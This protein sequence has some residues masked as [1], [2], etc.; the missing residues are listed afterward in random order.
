MK[1]S[2]IS[3]VASS[4][5][6]ALIVITDVTEQVNRHLQLNVLVVDVVSDN[7]GNV[8]ICRVAPVFHLGN[9][10]GL[11]SDGVHESVAVI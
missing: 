3:G 10:F 9:L 2:R 7:P 1:E 6:L 11:E 4:R 8:E 5:L